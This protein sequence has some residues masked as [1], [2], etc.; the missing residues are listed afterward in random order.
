VINFKRRPY[1]RPDSEYTKRKHTDYLVVH[2]AATKA[3]ANIGAEE[4]RE[5]HVDDNGWMDIG[6]HYVIRRDGTVENGR[7]PWAVG[8]G[9]AGYNAN[10]L[11]I[12]LVGGI[13]FD[14]NAEDNF[15]PAQK[16][17]LATLLGMLKKHMATSAKICG[18]RDF[19][20]VAKDCPSFEVSEWLEE[21]AVVKTMNGFAFAQVSPAQFLQ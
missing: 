6:Y 8:A 16:Q 14:G 13:D 3:T 9:V 18:H 5:W 11:H 20:K 4:I 7:P 15:T 1:L 21:P 19:P 2:C 10:S 17:A 12:C